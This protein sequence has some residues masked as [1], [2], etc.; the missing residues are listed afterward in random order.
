MSWRG[1]RH[2]GTERLLSRE[3]NAVVDSLNDLYGFLTSGQQ[4]INVREIYAH[5]GTF[6]TRINCEGRPVILDGDPISISQFYDLAVQQ[7]AE[8]IDRSAVKGVLDGIYGKLPSKT[9]ITGAVDSASVTGY[10]REMRDVLVKV[11]MDEYGNVGV[12]ISEPIDEYGNVL[13]RPSPIY[14]NELRTLL[15]DELSDIKGKLLSILQF[16]DGTIAVNPR[17][18]YKIFNGFGFTASH[19]F[20]GVASNDAVNMYFEN[21]ADSGRT[22]YIVIVEVVSFGQLWID[23]YRGVTASGGTSITP[24][25]LNFASAVDSVAIVKYGVTFTDGTLAHSTV[26]PGGSRVNA[27]GGAVEVGETVI[28][29]P[30]YS[31]LVQATNKSGTSTDL[32][33]RILWWEE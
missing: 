11:K 6:N 22:V 18:Q 9:D 25:N 5:S 3:W 20:E 32:S 28:I 7:M 19:R 12:R 15:A 23:I 14:L 27:V 4:D 24:V 17:F 8:A 31:F 2:K 21:P 33:V 16:A 10:A 1:L 29:P 30:G 13:T 26:C